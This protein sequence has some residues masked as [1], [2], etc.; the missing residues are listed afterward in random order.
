MADDDDNL[1][2]EEAANILAE[3]LAERLGYEDSRI[4][5]EIRTLPKEGES[6]NCWTHLRVRIDDTGLTEHEQSVVLSLLR[7]LGVDNAMPVKA[8]S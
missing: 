8:F 7:E 5:V 4:R 3:M 1:D 6:D 2:P